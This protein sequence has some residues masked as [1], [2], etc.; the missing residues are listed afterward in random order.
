MP[1]PPEPPTDAWGYRAQRRD[2]AYWEEEKPVTEE[3][4]AQMSDS[5]LLAFVRKGVSFKGRPGD[6]R[7][8]PGWL[9]QGGLQGRGSQGWRLTAKEPC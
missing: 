4:I 3:Q 8:P 9:A 7:G 1:P 6:Q 5:E 2:E